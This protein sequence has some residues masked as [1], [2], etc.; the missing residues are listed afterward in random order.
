MIRVLKRIYD[1]SCCL[2]QREVLYEFLKDEMRMKRVLLVLV[3]IVLSVSEYD[4]VDIP[5]VSSLLGNYPNPFNP[6]T[7][8]RFE[9]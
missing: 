4:E 2:C 5:R 1:F 7:T 3:L 9:V 8:I 6:S